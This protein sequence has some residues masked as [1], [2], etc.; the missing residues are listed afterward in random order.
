[1]DVHDISV[2]VLLYSVN[3]DWQSLRIW[4]ILKILPA[5]MCH[6]SL[7]TPI[8][9]R[10]FLAFVTDFIILCMASFCLFG[11]NSLKL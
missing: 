6:Q 5:E 10:H 9:F 7:S 2:L 8:F 3:H 4:V 11:G 1:M